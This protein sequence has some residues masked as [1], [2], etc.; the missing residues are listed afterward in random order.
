M[1]TIN[2]KILVVDDSTTNNF[3]LENLLQSD[4][5]DVELIENGLDAIKYLEKNMVALIILDIMMPD[6]S[7]IEVLKKIKNNS[8]SKDIPVII[9]S[10]I[11]N[12]KVLKQSQ[13]LGALDYI[14]KPFD[15][16]SFIT[17]INKY[18]KR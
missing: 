7:G 15:I 9:L 13:E 14:L 18:I 10:A 16:K 6:L 12:I 2:N 1:T 3:L 11:S 5:Y 17:K 4:G 8:D